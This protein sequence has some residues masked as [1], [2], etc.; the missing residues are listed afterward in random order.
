[1]KK[2]LVLRYFMNGFYVCDGQAPKGKENDGE[3]YIGNVIKWFSTHDEAKAML[4]IIDNA[5]GF[6][7]GEEYA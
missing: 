4:E 6:E 7:R 3:L 1:M 2:G 5:Y